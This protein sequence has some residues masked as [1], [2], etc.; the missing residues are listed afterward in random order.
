MLKKAVSLTDQFSPSASSSHLHKEVFSTSTPAKKKKNLAYPMMLTGVFCFSVSLFPPHKPHCSAL[1]R[2]V[3]GEG[4]SF[5]NLK[6]KAVTPV[7]KS[8]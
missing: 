3:G 6:L 5:R 1:P 2:G 4:F 7:T 8:L